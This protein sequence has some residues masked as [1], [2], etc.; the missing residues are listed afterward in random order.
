MQ[1]GALNGNEQHLNSFI[2]IFL[3][4]WDQLHNFKYQSIPNNF[5]VYD[6]FYC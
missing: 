5:T 4:K 1:S 2:I 6:T 3:A